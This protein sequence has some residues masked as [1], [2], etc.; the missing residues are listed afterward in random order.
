MNESH[1]GMSGYERLLARCND[2][3]KSDLNNAIR[4]AGPASSCIISYFDV[5]NDKKIVVMRPPCAEKWAASITNFREK[6]TTII[7]EDK[8]VRYERI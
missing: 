2:E 7:C 5:D 8:E 6:V 4:S 1:Y 3:E